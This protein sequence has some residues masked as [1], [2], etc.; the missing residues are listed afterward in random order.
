MLCSFALSADR[1]PLHISASP[2]SGT[3]GRR[4]QS[5]SR[6]YKSPPGSPL[7]PTRGG[8]HKLAKTFTDGV[9]RGGGPSSH[10]DLLLDHRLRELSFDSFLR[11]FVF[12]NALYLQVVTPR[13]LG[14]RPYVH[15]PC[16]NTIPRLHPP[17]GIRWDNNG[18]RVRGTHTAAPP[19]A[20]VLVLTE[21]G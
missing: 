11:L 19:T 14:G 18:Y 13:Y 6:R 7:F 1:Q 2:C 12:T 4:M 9:S 5:T 16:P 8:H 17:P 21:D 3:F 15:S 10:A 20:A